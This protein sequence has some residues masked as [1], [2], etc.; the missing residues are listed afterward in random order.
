MSHSGALY[1][2]TSSLMIKSYASSGYYDWEHRKKV[3]AA[4][5][6]LSKNRNG[7]YTL[8]PTKPTL[9]GRC[10]HGPITIGEHRSTQYL[11]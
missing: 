11:L 6:E 2:G 10:Q 1:A 9:I 7:N 8:Y 5:K 3:H 4:F